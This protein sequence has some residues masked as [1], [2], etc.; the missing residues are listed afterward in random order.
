MLILTCDDFEVPDGLGGTVFPYAGADGDDAEIPAAA[1]SLIFDWR[2][3]PNITADRLNYISEMTDPGGLVLGWIEADE[4]GIIDLIKSGYKL[5]TGQAQYLLEELT[6]HLEQLEELTVLAAQT[7]IDCYWWNTAQ[8]ADCPD[9]LDTE[10]PALSPGNTYTVPVETFR[11]SL[12]ELDVEVGGDWG[13]DAANALAL[14]FAESQL[15]C[16]WG[17]RCRQSAVKTTWAFRMLYPITR[18]LTRWGR[19]SF[20]QT[21]WRARSACWRPTSRRWPRR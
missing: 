6:S 4:P 5:K 8:T 10:D 19:S 21:Q 18:R 11:S 12:T 13:V 2:S 20:Q 1:F 14:A 9:D 7:Q 15:D 16:R 3:I 17:M